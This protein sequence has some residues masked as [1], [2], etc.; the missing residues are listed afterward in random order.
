MYYEKPDMKRE[1]SPTIDFELEIP[2]T[3]QPET[4]EVGEGNGGVSSDDET[5]TMAEKNE[6]ETTAATVTT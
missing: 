5:T 2:E 6:A 1:I 4:I 3:K